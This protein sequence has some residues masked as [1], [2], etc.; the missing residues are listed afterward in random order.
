MRFDTENLHKRPRELVKNN[1]ARTALVRRLEHVGQRRMCRVARQ[2]KG[3]SWTRCVGSPQ[4]RGT[5]VGDKTTLGRLVRLRQWRVATPFTQ[6]RCASVKIGTAR[7]SVTALTLARM[8]IGW[9]ASSTL[10][11]LQKTTKTWKEQEHTTFQLCE[12]DTALVAP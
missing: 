9:S 12:L 8:W 3:T 6:R 1:T 11:K 5:T 7:F 10:D 4:R 2:K